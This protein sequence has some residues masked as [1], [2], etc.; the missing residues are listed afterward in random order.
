MSGNP[1][2]KPPLTGS[3]QRADTY[4]SSEVCC[5]GWPGLNGGGALP[6]ARFLV[7]VHPVKVE[8]PTGRT[9]LTRW[10][11]TQEK[12][13]AGRV[14]PAASVTE[15]RRY[16]SRW[17][18]MAAVQGSA[19]LTLAPPRHRASRRWRVDDVQKVLARDEADERC[20]V[21]QTCC[22]SLRSAPV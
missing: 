3:S 5:L 13:A 12:M 9:T 18:S 8:S 20:S 6:G 22:V 11:I 2:E 1:Q 15:A 16:P 21:L 17:C 7:T 19:S 10:A 4:V 14:L